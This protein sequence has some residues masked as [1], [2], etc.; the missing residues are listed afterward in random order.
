MCRGSEPARC[1]LSGALSRRCQ[2]SWVP[3]RTSGEKRLADGVGLAA[4]V[5]RV[6]SPR[7]AP[8]RFPI[9][10]RLRFVKLD[11]LPLITQVKERL[12]PSGP[13][14][15]DPCPPGKQAHW[16]VLKNGQVDKFFGVSCP[17]IVGSRN[18]K[19][20]PICSYL[21]IRLMQYFT[22]KW[23]WLKGIYHNSS[24]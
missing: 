6:W 5:R 18:E 14:W 11:V 19:A 2:A 22:K 23:F 7:L 13:G 4:A 3:R 10:S 1:T 20:N 15:G 24:T 9:G 8:T 16:E 12:R 17:E 21:A